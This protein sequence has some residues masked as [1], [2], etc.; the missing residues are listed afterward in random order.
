MLFS[1]LRVSLHRMVVAELSLPSL[2][3]QLVETVIHA[4]C[5]RE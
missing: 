5:G 1:V 4:I 3:T 2:A